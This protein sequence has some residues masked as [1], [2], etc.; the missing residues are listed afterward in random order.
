ME[1]SAKADSALRL[2]PPC[3]NQAVSNRYPVI[4]VSSVARD[5]I[6]TMGTKRKFWFTGARLADVGQDVIQ[7]IVYEVPS[8]LI[9]DLARRFALAV[10]A[11][12]RPRLLEVA[13]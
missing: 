10:T 1:W 9:T 5:L 13:G 6:E 7:N 11:W 2:V 12:S 8:E 4:D 3:E